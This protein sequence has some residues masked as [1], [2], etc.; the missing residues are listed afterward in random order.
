MPF[1]TATDVLGTLDYRSIDQEQANVAAW[2]NADGEALE[3]GRVP[4]CYCYLGLHPDKAGDDQAAGVLV[5][6]P[7]ARC[8]TRTSRS[9]TALPCT[10]L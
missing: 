5:V 10:S 1:H 9:R 8:Y 7:A 2:P 6:A 4:D 3:P